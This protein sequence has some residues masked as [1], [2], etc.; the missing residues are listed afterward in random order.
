MLMFIGDAP[1]SMAGGI[2]TMT[3]V[4][5]LLT[6]WTALNRDEDIQVFRRRVGCVSR[7]FRME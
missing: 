5:L 2:K 7:S 1:G 3:F 6:T 4:V